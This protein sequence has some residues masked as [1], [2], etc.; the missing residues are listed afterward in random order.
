[1]SN[2]GVVTIGTGAVTSGKILDGTIVNAD[3][4][5]LAAIADS[6]LATISSSGKVSNSATTATDLNTAS[7][8]VARDASGNF[9]AGTITATSLVVPALDSVGSGVNMVVWNSSN[10]KFQRRLVG[11]INLVGDVSGTVNASTVSKINGASLG[12]TTATDKNILVANGTSWNS[13]AVSGDVTISNTGA[14]T[15]GTGAV[16]SA[17]ILDGTVANADLASGI[18]AAKIG[19]G[20]VSSTEFGYVDGVTSAIQTQLDNKVSKN[21]S[22][23]GA[24]KT[25]ITY[26]SKGLVTSGADATTSDIAEGSNLYYT[27]A[28]SRSALSNTATGLSYDNTSGVTSLASGYEI[29]TTAQRDVW[30]DTWSKSGNSLSGLGSNSDTTIFIGTTTDDDVIIKRNGATKISILDGSVS[31]QQGLDVDGNI[32]V[33]DLNVGGS[34]TLGNDMQ[35]YATNAT[36]FGQLNV[37]AEHDTSAFFVSNSG[38]GAAIDAFGDVN[39][40]GNAL[41]T[42]GLTVGQNITVGSYALVGND[43]SNPSENKMQVNGQV[44]VLADHDQGSIVLTNSGTGPKV[45]IQDAGGAGNA[46]QIENGAGGVKYSYVEVTVVNNTASIN[47][48]YSVAHILSDDDGSDDTVTLPV[49]ALPGQILYITYSTSSTDNLVVPDV[50]P[51]GSDYA[52]SSSANLTLVYSGGSW[53]LTG[54]VE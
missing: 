36:V 39:I 26:D 49:N 51:D 3:I 23:T 33:T 48:V 34:M 8:I 32:T 50:K 16:T 17:K 24:T 41:V 22:I 13:V 4:D 31:I 46:I 15:I 7:A 54:V 18:D 52:T 43:I 11:Y 19:A 9:S 21:S 6:K 2:L 42:Q 1:M 30:N 38:T 37:L 53:K 45:H 12:T 40:E 5:A 35:S 25:K 28:R 10:S 44:E 20:G 29:P 47:D 14:T 27:D